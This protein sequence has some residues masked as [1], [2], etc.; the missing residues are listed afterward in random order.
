[1]NMAAIDEDEDTFELQGVAAISGTRAVAS[2]AAARPRAWDNDDTFAEPLPAFVPSPR[3]EGNVLSFASASRISILPRTRGD[4]AVRE[5]AIERPRF[6]KRKP[7]G[8]GGS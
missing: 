3:V 4:C 6:E 7:L 8:G 5:D 1:M 2:G